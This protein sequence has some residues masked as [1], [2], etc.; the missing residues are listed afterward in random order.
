MTKRNILSY[1]TEYK[2]IYAFFSISIKMNNSK[3]LSQ[4]K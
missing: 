4:N 1:I 3:T 2:V